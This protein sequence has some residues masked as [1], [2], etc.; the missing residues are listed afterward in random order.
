[1]GN[2]LKEFKTTKKMADTDQLTTSLKKVLTHGIFNFN[3]A[4]GLNESCKALEFEHD[5]EDKRAALCILAEDCSDDNYKKLIAGLCKTW[6]VQLIKVSSRCDLGKMAGLYKND[7][8]GNARKIR[9]CSC[10]VVKRWPEDVPDLKIS[11]DA[12]LKS[13]ISFLKTSVAE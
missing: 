6:K 11:I 9:P 7:A 12:D 2:L 8:T 10:V 5:N 3:L 13:A 1:M 4:R